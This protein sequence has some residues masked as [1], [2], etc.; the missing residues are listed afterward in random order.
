M[1]K[2][3][4]LFILLLSI[5]Y[6]QAQEICDNGIDDTGNGL[7]DLNDPECDC[8]GFGVPQI[9]PSLIPNPSFENH[10]CC[11]TWFS[12]LY[13]AD[14]WMQA[15]NAT[16]DYFNC[17][18]TFNALSIPNLFAPDGTAFVGTIFQNGWKEYV[19]A[20][21]LSPLLAGETYLLS[22]YIASVGMTMF[23]NQCVATH[24]DVEVSIFGTSN[25]GTLPLNTY[26]CPSVASAAWSLIGS[27]VY[28]PIPV[29]EIITIEF[30]PTSDINEI[31]IG[32]PCNL[33]S[34]YDSSGCTPYF[35]YDKLILASTNFYN[36]LGIT[37]QGELCTDDLVLS[38]TSDSLGGD[39]QWYYEGIAIVGE[40]DSV[41]DVSA[42]SFGPGKYTVKYTLGAKCE[43]EYLIIKPPQTPVANFNHLDVCLGDDI[44]FLDSSVIDT[45][46][47]VFIDSW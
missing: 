36:S 14:T 29:W 23:T 31:M 10:T 1:R 38:S 17:G 4:L 27:K 41:L 18:Y 8:V 13:C 30:T 26:D 6:T 43:T 16:T 40:T 21:L 7:I 37:Q 3:S 42:N 20:C 5:T 25:C 24:G 15:T 47:G 35:V 11:P 34:D 44:N 28:S 46:G 19:G 2:L 39:W 45:S 9:I 22:F 32:A 12:H 33:T